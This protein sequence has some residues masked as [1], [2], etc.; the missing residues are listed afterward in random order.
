MK[1]VNAAI[2]QDNWALVHEVTGLPVLSGD[3][4]STAMGLKLCRIVGGCP[5]HKPSSTGRV[6]TAD[7]D[8][9]YP[10]VFDLKW[11]KE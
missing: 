2:K 3:V 4:Y 9:F 11:V 10:S 5:P 6:Y 1:Q 8:E 7:N